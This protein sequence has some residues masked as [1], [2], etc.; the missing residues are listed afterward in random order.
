MTKLLPLLGVF[1]LSAMMT[2]QTAIPAGTIIPVEL[3]TTID[4]K[5]WKPGKTVTADVAQ[6]V[7]LYNGAKIKAGT[8]VQG[9]VLSVTPAANS[10]P[11]TIILRFGQIDISGKTTPIITNLR[12]LAS[13]LRAQSAEWE[14]PA[15]DSGATAPG[16]QTVNLIGGEDPDEGD[17]AYREAGIVVRGRKTVGKTVFAGRWGVLSKATPCPGEGTF[18]GD[19]KP[20]ALWVFSY[21]ACG[22]YGYHLA[23]TSAGQSNPEGKIVLASKKGNLTL[24]SGSAL[25]LRAVGSSGH[26]S[27]DKGK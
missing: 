14:T 1:A 18:E 8:K 20:Q 2:A 6:D 23:I 25:L 4:A 22:V 11:A 13:N 24:Y 19:D 15:T 12:A 7:P 17:V 26:P 9:E 10:R 5:T 21:D 27:Q 3:N 16:A